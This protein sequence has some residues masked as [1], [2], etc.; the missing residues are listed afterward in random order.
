M[1]S[2]LS[3]QASLPEDSRGSWKQVLCARR[4]S[5][6]S[7]RRHFARRAVDKDHR[8]RPYDRTQGPQSM[9]TAKQNFDHGADQHGMAHPAKQGNPPD[10]YLSLRQPARRRERKQVRALG[11]L[12]ITLESNP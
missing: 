1:P 12:P 8:A 7:R 6:L 9:V 10:Q 11:L 3:I 5:L 2:T 4:R